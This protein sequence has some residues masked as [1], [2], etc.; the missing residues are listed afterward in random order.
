MAAR[1]SEDLACCLAGNRKRSLEIGFAFAAS[2]LRRLKRNRQK[3]DERLPRTIFH[4]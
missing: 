1:S 4:L 2:G 3:C